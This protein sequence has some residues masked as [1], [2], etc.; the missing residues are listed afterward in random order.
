VTAKKGRKTFLYIFV[1]PGV[2]NFAACSKEVFTGS[3]GVG[4]EMAAVRNL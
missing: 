3:V 4:S 1:T 2:R